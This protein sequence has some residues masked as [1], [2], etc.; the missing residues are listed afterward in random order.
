MRQIVINDNVLEHFSQSKR[1][2]FEEV[3]RNKLKINLEHNFYKIKPICIKKVK[4]YE[5]KVRLEQKNYRIAFSINREN[6]LVF[7]ISSKLIKQVF[8]EEVKKFINN[9]K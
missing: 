6:I 4:C 7:F 5:M 3:I 1:T 9:N 8:D 2:S